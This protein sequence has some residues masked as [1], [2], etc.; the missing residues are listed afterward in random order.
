MCCQRYWR[1]RPRCSD[2][3]PPAILRDTAA[4]MLRP[5]AELF[6]SFPPLIVTVAGDV[7]PKILA[8]PTPMVPLLMTDVPRKPVLLPL[9][10]RTPVPFFTNLPEAVLLRTEE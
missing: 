8:P 3:K 7:L 6:A 4:G 10:V 2:L 1:R 5:V 9:S